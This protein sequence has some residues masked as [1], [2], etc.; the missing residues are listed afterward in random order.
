MFELRCHGIDFRFSL[1]FPA[2]MVILL[3]LDKTGLA[4]WCVAASILHEAGHFFMMFALGSRPAQIIIGIFGVCVIQNQSVPMS[5]K[6]SRLVALAGPLANLAAFLVTTAGC[7]IAMPSLVH[8]VLAVFN[9]L[10]VEPLDGGQAL[11]FT[12]I[13]HMDEE[14]AERICLAVSVVTLVPLATGGFYL[15]MRS[16]YNF[17][18]LAV[19][20]YLGLL[21]IFKRK[22]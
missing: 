15:L 14:K 5:Y 9:L 7:G 10:P 21:L 1:L 18:L 17:T 4:A 20:L 12:L 13:S 19:S 2:A 11:Y 8:L 22:R 16:G 3:T 6:N